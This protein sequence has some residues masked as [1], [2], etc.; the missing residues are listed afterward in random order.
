MKSL[1]F[2]GAIFVPLLAV[3]DDQI[4]AMAPET[5][6]LIV[7][8]TRT[9]VPESET[10]AAVTVIEREEVE[11]AQATDIAEI[12][13]FE[14]GIDLGRTGGPGA[15]TSLFTRGGESNHTLVLIDGVRVNPA[16]SGGAALQNIAPHMIERIEV[17][18]GPRSTLYGSDAIAGVIN[19]ITREAEEPTLDASIQ[20]GGESSF[21]G[22]VNLGYGDAD[23]S[24]NLG[25]Q[26]STTDGI[27]ACAG[28]SVDRG[29]DNT[30][31]N[32]RG[33]ARVGESAE[34]FGRVWSAKG[35]AEYF[36]S[37]G[38]FGTPLDQDFHN[39]IGAV[40]IKLSPHRIWNS[41]LTISRS[42]DDIQQNQAN[43]LGEFGYVR[44]TRP[45]G[46][47]HNIVQLGQAHRLSF[48]VSAARE[49]VDALSF[50][51]V[52]EEKREIL[53]GFLQ[54]EISV[55]RNHLSAAINFSDYEGFGSQ[56]NWNLE[57]GFDLFSATKLIASAGTGFR[58]PDATD[59]FGFGG[60]PDL[61]PEE[62]TNY[63]IGLRQGIGRHQ[64]IDLRAFH[65]QVD[66]LITVAFSPANDPNVD[67]GFRA[68]NIDNYRN[69]GGELSWRFESAQWRA[70]LSGILQRPED[71]DTDELLLRRARKSLSA[72]IARHFGDKTYLAADLLGSG[73]RRDIGVAR[74]GGYALLNLGA[75]IRLDQNI[76]LQ[77][78]IEN[79]LD[80][81][82][83]TAAGFNQPGATGYVTLG[84][85]L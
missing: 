58:A 20:A 52:I 45:M 72:R 5:P 51:T 36:S 57:Y 12:L 85:S 66:D 10:L 83:Q 4:V 30:S 17:V 71:R 6:T 38:A 31:L 43:F 11:R 65:A 13:R 44:T 25:V 48:G 18:R 46:D 16:T 75:G 56:I 79:V 59:R 84:Y 41:Q 62:A 81:D 60:N 74:N 39:S 76:S 54:D 80:K 1:L 69:I 73:D 27:P 21:N 2:A 19:I 24:L 61:E 50:G 49:K 23:K 70:S 64:V 42:E 28:S 32:V 67:F 33:K 9:P 40:G 78:R 77:F 15:Q 34:L 3:A 37:C 53:A 14:A 8:A 63:E 68:V 35:N 22:A 29:Y 47:W 55:G 7:T 26:Q 82:Y